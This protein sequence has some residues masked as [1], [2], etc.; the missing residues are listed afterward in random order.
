MGSQVTL[1]YPRMNKL[2]QDCINDIS[3]TEDTTLH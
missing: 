2:F 3:Y 1:V